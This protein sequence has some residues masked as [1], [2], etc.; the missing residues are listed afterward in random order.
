MSEKVE[1]LTILDYPAPC[2]RK[3]AEPVREFNGDLA[4][5][6]RRMIELM[7]AARGVGLAAPQVGVLKRLFVMNASGETK[8]DLVLV[9]PELLAGE[10]P[11]EAEEGCLS[12]PDVRVKVRRYFRCH[13]RAFGL[14]GEPFE[15]EAEDL[16]ARVWQHEIDH[17]NGTLIIDRMGPS[18]RIAT[19]KR[20]RDL[21]ADY[22]E[23]HRH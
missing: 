12:I 4:A 1:Q 11:R 9:N 17:L 7:R 16:P 15:L 8:D 18:D 23:Q 3:V 21:E 13:I 2:L 22:R 5:L 14:D 19:R 6:A 10:R 20:L